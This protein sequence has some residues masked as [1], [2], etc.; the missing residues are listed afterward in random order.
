MPGDCNQTR[1]KFFDANQTESQAGYGTAM[2]AIDPTLDMQI[3]A[4]SVNARPNAF[5]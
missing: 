1:R 4:Q 3:A 5:L 2:S